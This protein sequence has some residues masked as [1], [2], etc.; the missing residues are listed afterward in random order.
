M[1]VKIFRR[2]ALPLLCLTFFS[3]YGALGFEKKSITLFKQWHYVDGGDEETLTIGKAT[4]RGKLQ[5]PGLPQQGIE[6][7]KKVVKIVPDPAHKS[8][9]IVVGPDE[10]LSEPYQAI[11]W[12][13]LGSDE[14]ALY[15]NPKV[16]PTVEA[17]EKNLKGNPKLYKTYRALNWGI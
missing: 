4:V 3:S 17:A 2:F 16:Y 9:V 13:D 7:E 5:G 11:Y 12:L 10:S 15:D 8:G 14:V 1:Q 6:M